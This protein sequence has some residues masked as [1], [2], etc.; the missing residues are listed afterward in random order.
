MSC[1]ICNLKNLELQNE[2]EN[3]LNENSGYLSEVNKKELK[4]KFPEY[5]EAIQKLTDNECLMHWNFHQAAK[6]EPDMILDK[7]N[8]KETGS[9]TK[10]INKDEAGV[11]Y[12]LMNKQAATFN[13]LTNKINKELLD[14]DSESSCSI[15]NPNVLMFYK[16][17]GDSI[18]LTAKELRELNATINGSKSDSLE[19]LKQLVVALTPTQS[20][21]LTNDSLVKKDMTTDKFDY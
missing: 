17:L 10:D 3:K 18:R 21:D 12:D 20:T 7:V 8:K 5:A 16:D 6:Y 11:L 1:S 15:M 14:E 13:C 9:L 19:G 4:E 2:I